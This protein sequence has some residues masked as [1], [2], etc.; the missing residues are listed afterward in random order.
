MTTYRYCTPEWLQESARIYRSSPDFQET[1]KKVTTKICFKVSAEPDWGIDEDIIFGA[2]VE[3]GK[4]IELDFFSDQD[5]LELAEFI[6]SATPQEWKLILRKDNKFITDFMLGKILLEQGSKIGIIGIAPYAPAFVDALTQ[7]ELQFP[8]EMS[9]EELEVYR[10]YLL[11][12][13]A[14]AGV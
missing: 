3:K 12:F 2:F 14:E 9:S 10:A 7:V 4:L 1:L 11:I 6:I 8:D 13:R 5:A